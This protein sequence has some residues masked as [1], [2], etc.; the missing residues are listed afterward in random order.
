M[1]QRRRNALTAQKSTSACQLF[2]CT[3]GHIIKIVSAIFVEKHFPG[4]GYCKVI[5]E[6]IQ[7][8]Y[9][10]NPLILL[11]T[12]IL[13]F[14][15]LSNR[16]TPDYFI[17]CM[18]LNSKLILLQEIIIIWQKFQVNDHTAV[19]SA[20]KHLQ[21]NLIFVLMFKLIQA[22]NPTDANIA[23]KHLH[24]NHI[25]TNMK[26]LLVWKMWLRLIDESF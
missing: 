9:S 13:K 6:L 19:K 24:L 14:C 23:G 22:T 12:F 25:C 21:T 1:T 5:W 15:N 2:Q 11:N 8:I 7:V 26:K 3:W 16:V 17:L 20:Q 10:I 18:T 4:H